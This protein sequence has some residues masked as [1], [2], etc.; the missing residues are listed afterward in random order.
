MSEFPQR[1]SLTRCLIVFS[2]VFLHLGLIKSIFLTLWVS[3]DHP[4][5]FAHCSRVSAQTCAVERKEATKPPSYNCMGQVRAY[6]NHIN[7]A[8]APRGLLGAE[9]TDLKSGL[10]ET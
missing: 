9:R 4:I 1:L 7:I 6:M 2:M 10:D 3:D 5:T 8:N